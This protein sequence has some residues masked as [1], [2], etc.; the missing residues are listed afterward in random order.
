MRLVQ[1]LESKESLYEHSRRTAFPFARLTVS[2]VLANISR[3]SRSQND[4]NYS[5]P[6]TLNKAIGIAF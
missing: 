3:V 5:S 6:A 2:M 1:V 4:G